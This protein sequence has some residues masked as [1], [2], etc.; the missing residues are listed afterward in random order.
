VHLVG[1]N[2]MDPP[3]GRRHIDSDLDF[4]SASLR[5]S[6]T[7]LAIWTNSHEMRA[8]DCVIPKIRYRCFCRG[9]LQQESISQYENE[10]DRGRA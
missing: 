2:R 7:V 6:G 10:V 5:R 4:D 3:E 1:C 8:S 9:A